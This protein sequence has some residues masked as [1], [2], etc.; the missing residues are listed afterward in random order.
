VGS[1][2]RAPE[3]GAALRAAAGGSIHGRGIYLENRGHSPV[4][5][6]E[7]FGDSAATALTWP[8]GTMLSLHHVHLFASDIGRTIEFWREHF[9]AAVVLDTTFAGARNVFLRVGEGRLHLYS[10]P[11]VHVGAGTVHHLGIETDVLDA[12]VARLRAAGVSVTDVRRHAEGDYAMA[13]APDGLLLE[14]F[15]PHAA[16]LPPDLARSGYF[17]TTSADSASG[18]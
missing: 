6:Q 18:I 12:L 14:I 17:A 9:G 2:A 11:P 4:F 1:R 5:G 10:Q 16:A 15:Q 7:R 8:E 3:A 13:E